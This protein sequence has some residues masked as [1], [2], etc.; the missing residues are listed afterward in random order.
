MFNGTR[1][2]IGVLPTKDNVS[3]QRL[4]EIYLAKDTASVSKREE[5]AGEVLERTVPVDETQRYVNY[6]WIM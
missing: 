5:V 3:A 2:V 6:T 4:H 1:D